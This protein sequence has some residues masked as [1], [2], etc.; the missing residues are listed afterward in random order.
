MNYGGGILL[1]CLEG[2]EVFVFLGKRTASPFRGYWSVSG[3]NLLEEREKREPWAVA[4][5]ETRKQLTVN[6]EDL[7]DRG[8]AVMLEHVVFKIPFVYRFETFVVALR[9]KGYIDDL[10]HFLQGFSETGWFTIRDLPPETHPGV[11]YALGAADAEQLAKK[12]LFT[13]GA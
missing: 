9:R 11:H 2:D 13:A 6:I 8:D 1:I 12:G 3:G 5:E 10:P 7:L 4:L